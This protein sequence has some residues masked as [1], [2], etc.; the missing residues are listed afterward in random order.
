M[1]IWA[2]QEGVGV[3]GA[4]VTQR[5]RLVGGS[6]SPRKSL[7]GRD[8]QHLNSALGLVNIC[9]VKRKKE[10][11]KEKKNEFNPSHFLLRLSFVL[12]AYQQQQTERRKK[13]KSTLV[14]LLSFGSWSF[15]TLDLAQSPAAK[16]INQCLVFTDNRGS[17]ALSLFPS[18][19]N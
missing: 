12:A 8:K 10:K 14:L 1:K 16:S 18:R 19:F 4:P 7:G 2:L 3:W 17:V 11:R 5:Q 9:T 6:G 13:Q 15:S